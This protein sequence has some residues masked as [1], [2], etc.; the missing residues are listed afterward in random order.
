[1]IQQAA[2]RDFNNKAE[3]FI[4]PSA[5]KP[6]MVPLPLTGPALLNLTA[7]LKHSTSQRT[8]NISPVGRTRKGSFKG[9]IS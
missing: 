4:N 7:T 5:G 2:S 1:M 3:T 9:T 6:L 8:Q